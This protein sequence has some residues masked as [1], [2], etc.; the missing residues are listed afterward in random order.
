MTHSGK[1]R[2][3]LLE[4]HASLR[5]LI[6]LW[7][8]RRGFIVLESSHASQASA[9]LRQ[10]RHID[11]AIIDLVG[12]GGLDLAAHIGREYH[13]VPILYI[14]GYANSLVVDAIGGHAPEALLLKPFREQVLLARVRR[15]LSTH[16]PEAGHAKLAAAEQTAEPQQ[17]PCG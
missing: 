4:D 7:L 15:L 12:T 9:V 16:R 14:S 6:A 2:V 13:G 11:L 8:R 3:L 1:W 17:L 5:R 10:R